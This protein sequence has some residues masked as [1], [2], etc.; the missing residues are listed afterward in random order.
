MTPKPRKFTVGIDVGGT[1][2]LAALCDARFRILSVVKMKSKPEKGRGRFLSDLADSVG[3]VIKEG[4]AARSEVL[5]VGVGCPG[6]V[7][8]AKGKISASPNLPFLAGFPLAAQLSKKLKLPVVVGNDAQIG[9]YGEHQFGAA[10]GFSNAVGLFLG[11]GVGGA[12][13]LEGRPYRGST[14]SAGEFGH[15]V[16]DPGG[17]LCGCGQ[18]GCLEAWIGRLAIASEAALLA[19]RQKAPYLAR[20]AGTDIRAIKSGILAKAIRSGDKAIAELMRQKAR[21]LGQ[22]MSNLVYILNPD[23]IVLGGGVVEAMPSLIAREAEQV[24]RAHALG[25]LA[26]HVRV[27]VAKLGDYSIVLGAAKRACDLFGARCTVHG[28]QKHSHG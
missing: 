20:K 25:P 14:G 4:G 6:L 28:A 17:P 7:D 3:T 10:K 12:M 22:A 19:A 18:R 8:P 2:I 5:A 11:T 13:I 23:V 26:R 16:I 1:K 21:L 15:M 24:L 27:K 9:L